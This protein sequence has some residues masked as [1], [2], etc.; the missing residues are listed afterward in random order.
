MAG[1]VAGCLKLK[2]F[3]KAWQVAVLNATASVPNGAKAATRTRRCQQRLGEIKLHWHDLR[4]EYASR[5]VEKGVP[6]AQVRDLLG[7]ASIV[8][9]ERYD[10]QRLE[11]LQ[12][13]IARL[14]AG[15]AFD[16]V[17]EQTPPRLTGGIWQNEAKERVDEGPIV[18]ESQIAG[19]PRSPL[20]AKTAGR[21]A[22][23]TTTELSLD[24]SGVLFGQLNPERHSIGAPQANV[25][26]C[27][28]PFCVVQHK[29]RECWDLR[30]NVIERFQRRHSGCRCPNG[31]I[32]C[33]TGSRHWTRAHHS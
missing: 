10:N 2:T 17:F 3:K 13:A 28:F 8:M 6:L 11:A 1:R 24:R 19:A 9:T 16:A 22:N 32:Q 5:L 23:Q 25:Q 30:N 33:A 29:P 14:E 20:S 4:H 26:W 12:A 21:L 31:C 27:L 18:E 15:K 7:H